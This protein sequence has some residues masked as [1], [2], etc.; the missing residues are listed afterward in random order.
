MQK[1]F[2]RHNP[3]IVPQQRGDHSFSEELVPEVSV[4]IVRGRARQR[5]RPVDSAAYLIG[6]A[7]DCDLVLAA[8]R[9]PEVYA[10]L[11]HGPQ[12]VA[13]RHLGFVPELK[14]NGKSVSS[15]G[16]SDGDHLELGPF[17]LRVHIQSSRS[18]GQRLD[19]V[20]AFE[21]QFSRS[22]S[23]ASLPEDDIRRHVSQLMRDI[24]Q[25]LDEPLTSRLT[26]GRLRLFAE[27]ERRELEQAGD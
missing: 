16:L 17:E 3:H 9:F 15:A 22:D 11:L 5:R 25:A 20:S 1:R 19:E 8:P 7:P 18:D 12:G 24:R 6:A 23:A 2:I 21:S 4:E 10:Y 14:V 13:I 26:P 27:A